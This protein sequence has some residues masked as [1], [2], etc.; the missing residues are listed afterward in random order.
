MNTGSLTGQIWGFNNAPR[1]TQLN[2]FYE[3]YIIR[4]LEIMY[5]PN[6]LVGQINPSNS[7]QTSYIKRV[8]TFDDPNTFNCLSYTPGQIY[9]KETYRLRDPSKTFVVKHDFNQLIRR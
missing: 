9:E 5:V 1:F 8:E 3:E 6:D 7:A 2:P 4:A